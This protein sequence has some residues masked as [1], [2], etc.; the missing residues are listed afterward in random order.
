MCM[1]PG[2]QEPSESELNIIFNKIEKYR[3][4]PDQISAWFEG[5]NYHIVFK[6]YVQF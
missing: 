3:N 1:D 5:N 6:Y 2:Y 4:W